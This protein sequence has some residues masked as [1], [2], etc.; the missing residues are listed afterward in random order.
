MTGPAP[1]RQPPRDPGRQ[2]ER[3]A[4]SWRRTLLAATVAALLAARMAVT[5][6]TPV[7]LV[8]VVAMAVG[9]LAILVLAV[10]RMTAMAAAEPGPVG[11]AVPLTTLVT[12]VYAGLGMVLVTAM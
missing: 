4:L 3:T 5:E 10:R 7:A 2:P 12:A 8:A 6:P 11:W 9:W 1:A